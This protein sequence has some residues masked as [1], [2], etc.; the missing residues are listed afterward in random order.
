MEWSAPNG[1]GLHGYHESGQHWKR[2]GMMFRGS[3]KKHIGASALG[4]LKA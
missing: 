1:V 4:T 3:G 2:S